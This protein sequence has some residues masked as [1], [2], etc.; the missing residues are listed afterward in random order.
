[1]VKKRYIQEIED[2]IPFGTEGYE[3]FREYHEIVPDAF[4]GSVSTRMTLEQ[5][6]DAVNELEEY[7]GVFIGEE[8]VEL[9]ADMYEDLGII[10]SETRTFDGQKIYRAP[11]YHGKGS[12]TSWDELKEEVEKALEH[13]ERRATHEH[14][15]RGLQ[16][17]LDDIEEA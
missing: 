7:N 17:T 2:N 13:V 16:M 5:L 11:E 14:S 4:D 3:A 10:S 15:V 12:T 9:T 1:M 8:L 6:N